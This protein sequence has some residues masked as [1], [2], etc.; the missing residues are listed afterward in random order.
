M[1]APEPMT[2]ASEGSHCPATLRNPRTLCWSS[3][4]A[5]AGAG[6]R[7]EGWA[8]QGGSRVSLSRGKEG[9]GNEESRR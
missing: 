5:P 8:V 6:R 3:M 7:A 1:V 4:P 9:A 2:K